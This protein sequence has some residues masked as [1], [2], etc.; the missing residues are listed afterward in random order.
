MKI[1]ILGVGCPKCKQLT[2]NAEAAVKEL[3]IQAEIGKVTDIDKITEYGV[4]M[5]PALA[6][7]GTVVS[8]G[9][10]LTKDEIK[11]VISK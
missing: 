3:N 10:V 4:M 9:K 7:D 5:T 11:K 8:A 1:E 6:I 2:A